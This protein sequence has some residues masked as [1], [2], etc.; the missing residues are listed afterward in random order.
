MTSILGKLKV[1]VYSKKKLA[2]KFS[3]WLE[4]VV[5]LKFEKL[6][7]NGFAKYAIFEAFLDFKENFHLG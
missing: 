7:D 2:M 3:R 5:S 1:L 4:S 6:L